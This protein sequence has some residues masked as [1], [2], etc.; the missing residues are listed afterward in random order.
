M[1][2]PSL[3][4]HDICNGFAGNSDLYGLGIRIGIYLQWISSLSTNV[5]LPSGVSDSLDTNS[6]FLFAIFI[7]VANATNP[8]GGLHPAEALIMLQL[9][10]GYLLSVLTVSGL[11]LTLFHDENPELLLSKLRLGPDLV[12]ALPRDIRQYLDIAAILDSQSPTQTLRNQ[13]SAARF[14]TP[15]EEFNRKPPPGVS[16]PAFQLY[17]LQVLNFLAVYSLL[18]D[19]VPGGHRSIFIYILEPAFWILDFFVFLWL[20]G[21]SVHDT[22]A[23]PAKLYRR[24]RLLNYKQNRKLGMEFMRPQIFSLGLTSIYKNDQV[25][26]LGVVWRSCIVAGIGIYNIWFWFTGIEFLKTDSC[27]IYVFLFYKANILGSPR[28]FFKVVSAIYM[29]YGGALVLSC[30][31]ILLAFIGTTTRSLLINFII[32]PYAKLLLLVSTDSEHAKRRLENFD[33]TCSEFLKWLDIPNMRQLLSG[34]AYLSSNAKEAVVL[35]DTKQDE[36]E[37]MQKSVW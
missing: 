11:R 7:A 6:I 25:S 19:V 21:F 16:V 1:E 15:F 32:M 13:L 27:P 33:V 28:T 12:Y 30:C 14:K 34:F 35:K 18:L 9:C 17:L 29:V 36:E 31:Y 20:A 5:L 8:P 4:T 24:E 37:H 3:L 23:D 22:S 2:L 10:F 26:W